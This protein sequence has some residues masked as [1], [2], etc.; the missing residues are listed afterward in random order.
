MAHK[1]W[2]LCSKKTV[3]NRDLDFPGQKSLKLKQRRK[4]ETGQQESREN[5]TEKSLSHNYGENKI[6]FDQTDFISEFIITS[7]NCPKNSFSDET[8]KL[9]LCKKEK[10]E[11][12]R[13]EFESEGKSK[14]KGY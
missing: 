1:Q 12:G 14:G 7:F 13:K 9:S 4:E 11:E 6:S 2:L 3:K 8:T 5:E 10:S